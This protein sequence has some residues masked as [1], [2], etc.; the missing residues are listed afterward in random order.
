MCNSGSGRLNGIFWT[1]VVIHIRLS[2]NML[3][4]T[5]KYKNSNLSTM[6]MEV[7][8]LYTDFTLFVPEFKK[9]NF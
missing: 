1:H 4:Q 9:I 6:A 5:S 3:K 8:I 7:G 2:K